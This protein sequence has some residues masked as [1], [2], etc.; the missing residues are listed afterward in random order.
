[1]LAAG[2]ETTN[3]VIT[4]LFKGYAHARDKDFHTWI[5]SKKQAYFNKL[6]RINVNGLDFKELV[7]NYYND[8]LTAGECMQ[9]NDEQ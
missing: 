3:D 4:N 9:P 1:M 8:A 5:K 2:G 6:F 7:E